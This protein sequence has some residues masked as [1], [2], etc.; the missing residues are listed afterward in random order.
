[1]MILRVL[2]VV[3][4]TVVGATVGALGHAAFGVWSAEQTLR[5]ANLVIGTPDDPIAIVMEI[6]DEDA[7]FER[8]EI[9]RPDED[10]RGVARFWL[11][12]A[13]DPIV[14]VG[15]G[16]QIDE[17]RFPSGGRVELS[18]PDDGEVEARVF[19]PGR[20]RPTSLV[21]EVPEL[22][23]SSRETAGLSSGFSSGFIGEA[24]A[25]EAPWKRVPRV[26]FNRRVRVRVHA[27]GK[28]DAEEVGFRL[29]CSSKEVVCKRMDAAGP[30]PGLP[31]GAIHE[32]ETSVWGTIDTSDLPPPTFNEIAGEEKLIDSA[33]K[34]Q[35]EVSGYILGGAAFVVGLCTQVASLPGFVGCSKAVVPVAGVALGAWNTSVA[36]VAFIDDKFI[37]SKTHAAIASLYLKAA[38]E[39]VERRLTGL[40]ASVCTDDERFEKSCVAV[41]LPPLARPQDEPPTSVLRALMLE[42]KDAP[43]PPSNPK[44]PP[45]APTELP[46][47]PPAKPAPPPSRPEKPPTLDPKAKCTPTLE[48]WVE[49]NRSRSASLPLYSSRSYKSGYEC[50]YDGSSV[51]G[52]GRKITARIWPEVRTYRSNCRPSFQKSYLVRRRES[53]KMIIQEWLATKYTTQLTISTF[54]GNLVVDASGGALLQAA[55][56]GGFGKPCR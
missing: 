54:N 41:P 14:A 43:E 31:V 17:L 15:R 39:D 36:V 32:V 27:Q 55:I 42:P 56:D 49:G 34:L 6:P 26:D 38:R 4:L 51:S 20:G 29:S 8:I 50:K 30:L 3:F 44:K 1:M 24:H 19:S 18:S 53:D 7:P 40:V 22:D 21:L 45:P 37:E 33:S 47:R 46:P 25:Q 2:L 23:L 12:D 48:V 11:H 35:R 13:E 28:T 52:I 10:G 16:G 9:D 5:D